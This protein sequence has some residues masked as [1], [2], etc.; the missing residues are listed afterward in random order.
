AP[1]G[2]DVKDNDFAL[3]IAELDFFA[4]EV[5]QDNLRRR[6]ADGQVQH[7]I[8]ILVFQQLVQFFGILLGLVGASKKL[9][10]E[11]LACLSFN[12]LAEGIVFLDALGKTGNLFASLSQ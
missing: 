10:Q 4:V 1:S 11:F 5:L 8:G 6:F 9:A 7:N 2:P 3:E 12:S